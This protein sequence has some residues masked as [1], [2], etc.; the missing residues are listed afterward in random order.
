MSYFLLILF[1]LLFGRSSD[2]HREMKTSQLVVV[3]T[4]QWNSINGKMTSYQ[5]KNNRWQAVFTDIPIVTGRNG[6]AWGKGLHDDKL[7]RGKLKKEGDGKAPAGIF[8]LSGLFGYKDISSKMNS[9]K[10]D[11][12]TF[13]VDDVKSAFYNQIV[14]SDTV[15]KDWDSAETMR[16]KSDV[17]KFGIFVDYNVK[18]AVPGKGSCIFM[19]IWSKNNAPTA[20]C[21]AMTEESILRL[22][23]FLDK[24]KNPVLVQIPESEYPRMKQLYKLP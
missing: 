16:M 21:T 20:G 13:C 18:P 3:T 8:Y 10:V 1:S 15:K 22:I 4:S 23:N 17:Y 2:I 14:K 24:S 12:N 11:Q 9:L 7:N 5:W 19:H 6:L